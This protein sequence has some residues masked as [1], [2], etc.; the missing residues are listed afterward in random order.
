MNRTGIKTGYLQG[1][2]PGIQTGK[3]SY[4]KEYLHIFDKQRT[5]YGR[6]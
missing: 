6:I 1:S 5:D 3:E 4:E 2:I